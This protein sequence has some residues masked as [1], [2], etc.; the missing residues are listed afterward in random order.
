MVTDNLLQRSKLIQLLYKYNGRDS[1]S[2]RLGVK[3]FGGQVAKAGN[4]IVRQRGTKYHPGKNVYKG[5]DFTLHARVDGHVAFRK[6]KY[7]RTF[8]DILPFEDVEIKLAE[9]RKNKAAAK[10]V[11]AAARAARAA[12]AGDVAAEAEAAAKAKAEAGKKAKAAKKAEKAAQAAA[13]AAATSADAV[14]EQAEADKAAD[15][16][17]KQAEEGSKR[18]SRSR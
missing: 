8:V 1:I 15:K 11:K 17:V 12:A 4:I 9:D 6:R 10:E 16:A 2:K 14:K 13:A 5:K 3:L 18:R 7:N